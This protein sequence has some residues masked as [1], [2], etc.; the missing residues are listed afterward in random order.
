MT[1][2]QRENEDEEQRR[3]RPTGSPMREGRTGRPDGQGRTG[4]PDGEGRQGSKKNC[5]TP[6]P[7]E[8]VDTTLA[9]EVDAG[10]QDVNGGS[11]KR[12]QLLRRILQKCEYSVYRIDEKLP[13]LMYVYTSR[14]SAACLR[15]YSAQ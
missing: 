9:P 10:E 6:A 7:Q 15:Q 1:V 3:R 2:E 11:A 12:A 4:R 5:T 14:C 8:E 13:I